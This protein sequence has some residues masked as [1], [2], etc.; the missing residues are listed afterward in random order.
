M[1]LTLRA[2][3]GVAPPYNEVCGAEQLRFSMI[4]VLIAPVPLLTA[5][6]V[7]L[8]GCQ[9]SGTTTTPSQLTSTAETGGSASS[10]ASGLVPRAGGAGLNSVEAAFALDVSGASVYVEPLV[11]DYRRSAQTGPRRL[12]EGDLQLGPSDRARLQSLTAGAF[13]ERFLGPRGGRLATDPGG[14]DYRLRLRLE[15]FALS[16]P[17]Q[18]TTGLQRTFARSSAQGTL[19]GG[20]YNREGQLVMRFRSRNLYRERAGGLGSARFE[21]FSSAS[22]WAE[23]RASMRRTFSSLGAS[24]DGGGR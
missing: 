8:G 22:F 24:L 18:L 3:T 23:T 17:L 20:L 14:A 10:G 11:I 5:V 19:T 13:N 4:K 6:L 12:G 15:N 21:R 2:V 1:G 16:G 7:L 9:Q